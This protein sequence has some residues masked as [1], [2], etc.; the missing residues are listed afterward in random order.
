MSLVKSQANSRLPDIEVQVSAAEARKNILV[1]SVL[2]YETNF[3][4]ILLACIQ[5]SPI[6]HLPLRRY[7]ETNAPG[8]YRVLKVGYRAF[9]A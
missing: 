3:R 8:I 5:Y 7:L 4:P 1:L 6:W 2:L 9:S